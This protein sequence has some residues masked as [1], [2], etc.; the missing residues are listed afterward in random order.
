MLAL[1]ELIQSEAVQTRTRSLYMVAVKRA[2]IWVG[3]VAACQGQRSKAPSSSGPEPATSSAAP[4]PATAPA[5]PPR[6]PLA[7]SFATLPLSIVVAEPE[8]ISWFTDEMTYKVDPV[9]EAACWTA[10]A[11]KVDGYYSLELASQPDDTAMHSF[12][13]HGHISLDELRRCRTPQEPR[14]ESKNPKVLVARD[15]GFFPIVMTDVGNDWML[16]IEG[17]LAPSLAAAEAI[18]GEPPAAGKN[19]LANIVGMKAE[20]GWRAVGLD[21]TSKVIGVPSI[22]VRADYTPTPSSEPLTGPVTLTV[23]FASADDAQRA[24]TAMGTPRDDLFGDT[25]KRLLET[26]RKVGDVRIVG[27][28]I[29]YRGPI[30]K[31][32]ADSEQMFL[33][34]ARPVAR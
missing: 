19:G 2:W 34:W 18:A 23:Y 10:I 12:A 33:G 25:P 6:S 29:V 11:P 32:L 9:F 7:D 17:Y 20:P 5:P 14:K 26:A 15:S 31:E 24:L 30:T 28:S 1:L 13:V 4:S 22:G 21:M 8:P 16:M 27:A 3:L